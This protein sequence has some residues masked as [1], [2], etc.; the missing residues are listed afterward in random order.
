LVSSTRSPR[1]AG[2]EPG[3]R[4]SRRLALIA[5]VGALA[6]GALA[7]PAG[8]ALSAVGPVNP[9]TGF[10]DWY[11]DGTGLKL[12]PCLDGPPFCLTAAAELVAPGG[13]GFWWQAEAALPLGAAGQARL[14]LAQEAAFLDG[15]RISFGRVRITVTGARGNT[16]YNFNHPYGS[17]SVTTDGL[18]S[19]RFSADTGCAAA[20]CDW[21]AALGGPFT[22]FLR[23]NPAVPPAAPAGFIGDAATPHQVTGGSVRNVFSFNGAGLT[24]ATD[25]F[26]VAG[27][28]AGPP[29]PVIEAPGAADFGATQKGAPVARTI[30]VTSF[31]VPDAAGRSNLL[32]GPI[33]IAGPQA[34]AFQLVGNTCS[35]RAIPSGQSCQLTVQLNPVGNG[36]YRA[37]LNIATNTAEGATGVALTGVVGAAGAAGASARSRRLRVHSLR[38]THRLSRAQVLRRGL[39]L[40]MRLPQ[41][42]EIVKLSVLRVRGNGRVDRKP[43][44]LAYRVAPSRAGLWRVRLDSRALRRRLRAGLYQLNVTP[45]VSRRRLGS[46]STTRIRITRR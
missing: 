28:L 12:Q 20:P 11:Q 24:G 42:T 36:D 14:V 8:A 2:R 23:W 31:G 29:V 13:E 44:W 18:G 5:A 33:G 21:A 1:T 32:F 43:V 37:A 30:I 17:A 40:T 38:T 34:S 4:R 25:L 10:P 41:G 39:R 22:N 35:G 16:T 9:A 26:T 3:A 6:A 27:K 19:G 15:G 7:A 46:T 45:G